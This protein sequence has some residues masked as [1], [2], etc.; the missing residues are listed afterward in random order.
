MA[1]IRADEADLAGFI[2]RIPSTRT[3]VSALKPSIGIPP[4]DFRYGGFQSGNLTF[5]LLHRLASAATLRRP[6]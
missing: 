5:H 6:K 3:G 2:C 4:T 1:E